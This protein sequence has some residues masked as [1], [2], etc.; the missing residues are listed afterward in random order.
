VSKEIEQNLRFS[1][2]R[3][4]SESRLGEEETVDLTTERPKDLPWVSPTLLAGEPGTP[5]IELNVRQHLSRQLNAE[6]SPPDEVSYAYEMLTAEDTN[7]DRRQVRRW[8]EDSVANGAGGET[9]DF[10]QIAQI[11]NSVARQAKRKMRDGEKKPS[12]K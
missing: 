12:A 3:L 7:P 6:E 4:L 2:N 9:L 1:R 11:A 8:I 10:A 5:S